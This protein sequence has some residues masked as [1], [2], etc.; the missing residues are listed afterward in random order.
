MYQ[1]GGSD[2]ENHAINKQANKSLPSNTSPSLTA[3]V[4]SSVVIPLP[5]SSLSSVT[6][7]GVPVAAS[8]C[9]PVIGSTSL[10][11]GVGGAGGSDLLSGIAR[12]AHLFCKN[13]LY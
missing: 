1:M 3:V 8:R 7:A 2:K 10:L 13:A 9:T 5:S 6:G 4:T 11:N 12:C